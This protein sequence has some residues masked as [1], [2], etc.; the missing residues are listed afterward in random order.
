MGDFI[1]WVKSKVSI[2]VAFGIYVITCLFLYYVGY[3]LF[4]GAVDTGLVYAVSTP[5]LTLLFW[6]LRDEKADNLRKGTRWDKIAGIVNWVIIIGGAGFFA[7][8]LYHNPYE[9]RAFQI[10]AL[11]LIAGLL[12]LV[13]RLK[14]NTSFQSCSPQVVSIAYT[15]IFI[16]TVMYVALLSPCTLPTA[17]KVLENHNYSNIS[18]VGDFN[19]KLTLVLAHGNTEKVS[20]EPEHLGVYLFRA[21]KDNER[22][23]VFVSVVSGDIV[24]S[25]LEN[26]NESLKYLVNYRARLRSG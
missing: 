12:A 17:Q 22:H 24:A 3:K 10:F 15:A 23:F 20:Q 5:P 7:Y 14:P 8:L 9:L 2:V 6:F 25:D 1:P 11:V 13:K 26:N 18:Y 21:E 4:G 19:N 16:A